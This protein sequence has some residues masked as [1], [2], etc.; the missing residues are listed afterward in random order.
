M[1]GNE[2]AVVSDN[3]VTRRELVKRAGTLA[4]AMSIAPVFLRV[5][6][7]DVLE[8]RPGLTN[9]IANPRAMDGVVGWGAD[10][11]GVSDPPPAVRRRSDGAGDGTTSAELVFTPSDEERR[12]GLYPASVHVV[13][14][15]VIWAEAMGKVVSGSSEAE[16]TLRLSYFDVEGQLVSEP[17]VARIRHPPPGE[18]IHLTGFDTAPLGSA[19]LRVLVELENTVRPASAVRATNVMAILDPP[20]LPSYFDG[21]NRGAAWIGAPHASASSSREPMSV[22]RAPPDLLFGFNDNSVQTTVAVTPAT[23]VKLN[24]EIGA[25]V[26]RVSVNL[27]SA[28]FQSG[29]GESVDWSHEY[30]QRYD[31]LYGGCVR[32]G[33]GFLPIALFCPPWMSV[34]QGEPPPPARIEE[35]ADLCAQLVK[36]WPEATAIE[37]WNEPNLG[38]SSWRP[39]ADPVAYTKLLSAA[40]RAVKSE[41]PSMTVLTGGLSGIRASNGP[42]Q[43]LHGFLSGMYAAG[44]KDR[45]D[46]HSF[47]FYP[48]RPASENLD[49][50][51]ETIRSIQR[52]NGD[53]KP[54]WLTEIGT[55]TGVTGNAFAEPLTEGQQAIVNRLLYAMLKHQEDLRAVCFHTLLSPSTV[56][57]TDFEAGFEFVERTTRRRKPVFRALQAELWG[58]D[59]RPSRSAG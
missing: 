44:A 48:A 43:A 1:T 39:A 12:A 15:N 20:G 5:E 8:A 32:A 2:R 14:G 10:I 49:E 7:T 53:S 6:T 23:D 54:L 58:K 29:P 41:N 42:N 21:D 55:S 36:R 35:W 18:W 51:F 45:F 52:Q 13:E 11:P 37:I 59:R 24:K 33:I 50:P 28:A 26:L 34:Q 9:L 25:S 40:Y 31:A 47:H 38:A 22:R 19:G 17:T 30:V 46:G 3:G 27:A 57:Q 16:L 56:P 4:G